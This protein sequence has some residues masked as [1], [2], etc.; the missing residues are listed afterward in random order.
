M[1]TANCAALNDLLLLSGLHLL[2]VVIQ[3]D[4]CIMI[5]FIVTQG[6]LHLSHLMYIIS[7]NPSN[8]PGL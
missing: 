1:P 5:P 7:H 2:D 4:G 3:K 6:L 8:N